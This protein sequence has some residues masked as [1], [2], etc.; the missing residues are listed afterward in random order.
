M[1][2]ITYSVR[3]A[4][5]FRLETPCCS[6][7]TRTWRYM[8]SSQ[9]R[10]P[11]EKK[12]KRMGRIEIEENEDKNSM[13]CMQHTHFLFLSRLLLQEITW[14]RQYWVTCSS[15]CWLRCAYH[16]PFLETH[17]NKTCKPRSTK[18]CQ[19]HVEFVD[20]L[21]ARSNNR[22]APAIRDTVVNSFF[23][24][25]VLYLFPEQVNKD[26]YLDWISL[27]RIMK[28]TITVVGYISHVTL[29]MKR[30]SICLSGH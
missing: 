7:Q 29:C 2:L 26:L 4:S 25:F 21:M 5:M 20:P 1:S 30:L 22:S 15:A 19:L 13:T 14:H 23:S 18:T 17:H 10:F 8:T 12:K 16:C 3:I 27:S 11:W 6:N 24:S 28:F 9:E